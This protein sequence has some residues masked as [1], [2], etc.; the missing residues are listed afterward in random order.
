MLTDTRSESGTRRLYDEA[1]STLAQGLG[2]ERAVIAYRDDVGVLALGGVYGHEW[3]ALSDSPVSISLIRQVIESDSNLIYRDV[4]TDLDARANVSLQLS[5]AVSV[6]CIPFHTIDG[7]VAGAMYV[8]TVEKSGSFQRRELIFA[9]DCAYWLEGCLAGN[10]YLPVPEIEAPQ[11]LEKT[12]VSPISQGSAERGAR[13]SDSRL[14]YQVPVDSTRLMI[15]FRSLAALTQAGVMI[16]E[17]LDLLARSSDD[18]NL[19]DVLTGL[20]DAV[21]NGEP[22]SS[23]MERYPRA[24]PSYLCSAIR[25][26]ER[27]G[28][29]V[30]VLDVLSRDLEKGQRLIYKL[31]SALTY[32]FIL[33]LACGLLLVL[34]PPY[35]LQGHLK[36]LAESGVA[37]PFL[38][39]CLI[40]LSHLMAHPLFWLVLV[41]GGVAAGVYLRGET[42]RSRL[43]S[44]GRR[45]PVVGRLMSQVSMAQFTRILCLQLRSGL[46]IL[47]AL[48]QGRLNCGDPHLREALRAAE[49]GIRNGE[50]L[51]EALKQT[52]H[53]PLSYLSFIEAGESV[54]TLEQMT[55]VIADYQEQELES[56]LEQFVVLVEPII[57]AVMG[58]VTALLLVATIKPTLLILQTL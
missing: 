48:G 52:G 57:L 16:H 1:A 4:R 24:F 32:P 54:G 17:S 12:S 27:S 36:M 45:L 58:A 50:T 13:R 49:D 5:G 29:L 23:A 30:R 28:R 44:L 9:R 51:T 21:R 3:F 46:T 2:A 31:R 43:L 38:T 7:V 55:E 20:S 19:G 26:G 34:G 42:G 6:M 41:T 40:A 10:S 47:E 35:L 15:C 39:Q 33:S 18:G 53:F 56:N 14:K 8:D 37:L 22:L 11:K 25:I